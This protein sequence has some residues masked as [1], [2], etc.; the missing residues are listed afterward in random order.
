MNIVKA[1]KLVGPL[2]YVCIASLIGPKRELIKRSE[3]KN[4]QRLG[5]IVRFLNIS[6]LHTKK[7]QKV[8]SFKHKKCQL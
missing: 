3:S 2:C 8:D 5:N 1:S 6:I 4:H 7:R